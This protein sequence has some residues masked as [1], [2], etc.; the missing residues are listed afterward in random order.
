M[1]HRWAPEYGQTVYVDGTILIKYDIHD[2][3]NNKEQGIWMGKHPM[4]YC[5]YKELEV[6]KNKQIDSPATVDAQIARYKTDGLPEDYGL[7]RGCRIIRNR[8][9]EELN[10]AWWKEVNEGCWRDQ[11][12]LSYA[13]WKTGIRPSE[14]LGGVMDSFFRLH[15]HL[16]RSTPNKIIRVPPGQR[17]SSVRSQDYKNSWI[18]IGDFKDA[19]QAIDRHPKVHAIFKGASK[20]PGES[21]DGVMCMLRNENYDQGGF[22]FQGWLYDYLPYMGAFEEHIKFYNGTYIYWNEQRARG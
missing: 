7:W 14:V 8:G 20:G 6:I 12:A 9:V 4:R 3:A 18:C 5:A 15:L 16:P 11:P 19:E 2:L 10:E 17:V 13:S 22:V 21:N 1:P